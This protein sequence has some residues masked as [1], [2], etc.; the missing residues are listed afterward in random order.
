[1]ARSVVVRSALDG[2]CA[3]GPFYLAMDDIL[4]KLHP[5]LQRWVCSE[6][7]IIKAVEAAGWVYVRPKGDHR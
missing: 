1:M 7:S 4:G 6:V 5:P 3:V 2:P